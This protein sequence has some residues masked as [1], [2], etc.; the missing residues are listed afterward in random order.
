MRAIGYVRLRDAEDGDPLSG[1]SASRNW[2][3]SPEDDAG[4]WG[5]ISEIESRFRNT[6]A[7]PVVQIVEFCRGGGHNLTAILGSSGSD[8]F[9]EA[10]E[11][12]LNEGLGTA[13]HKQIPEEFGDRQFAELMERLE[14]RNGMPALVVIP[15][16]THLADDLE[17]LVER[18]LYIR[19]SG[20]DAICTD[21]ELPDPLQNGEELLG[22]RGEPDWLRKRIRSTIRE[23]A[24]RGKVLGRTPYG[25]RC[26]ADGTLKPVPDEAKVV[27]QIYEW[28]VGEESEADGD[29]VVASNGLGM[30]LI[31][32]RLAAEGVPTRTGKPW[33]TATVSIILK[34]RVYVGTY[35]RYGFLVSGNHEPIIS[36]SLFRKAQDALMVKQRQR[37][38]SKS[39]DPFLLGG[40]LRCG[41][42]GHGVPGL[43]RRRSWRRQDNTT[44]TKTYRYYEFYECQY[45]RSGKDGNG[46]GQ[47]PKWRA[48][49][50][51]GEVRKAVGS[52][53]PE[54][55]KKI[56][57]IDTKVPLEEQL[58]NAEKTFLSEARVV[59]TG[60]GDL[61]NLEPY[62]SDIKRIRRLI[63][64][65]ERI[66]ANRSATANG[67]VPRERLTRDLIAD[68]VGSDDVL[69]AREALTALVNDVVVTDDSVTV[70][71]RMS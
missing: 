65:E 15:D 13:F 43:S 30:R 61:E 49:D 42:C 60:R 69:K 19:R 32:Q 68:V 14:G 7:D 10:V 2:H 46:N 38:L 63:E 12:E 51:D 18:L 70:K 24:S 33:S 4:T 11:S 40:I 25:Y 39:E 20:S 35:T 9:F 3:G 36:R 6:S 37:R 53:L 21:I 56:R 1:D 67:R 62:L 50:L 71:P 27:K 66:A 34:N 29:G 5:Q 28:Y 23:K 8:E 47:C 26:G 64:E 22:L 58:E 54:T 55:V 48:D 57:P 59:S 17:T 41:E 44:A 16:S 52:W 45:R 31:A